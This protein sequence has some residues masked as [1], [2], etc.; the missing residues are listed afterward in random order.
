MYELKFPDPEWILGLWAGGHIY[1]H[2]YYVQGKKEFTA[3]AKRPYTPVTPVD[4]KGYARFIIKIYRENK[5]FPDG[6]LFTQSLE[7]LEVGDAI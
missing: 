6:G 1:F 5:D 7:A 4:A 3:L 2:Q